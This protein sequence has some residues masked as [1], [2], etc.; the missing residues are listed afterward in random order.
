[1]HLKNDFRKDSSM[2]KIGLLCIFLKEFTS[3]ILRGNKIVQ[4]SEVLRCAD[5]S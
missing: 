2:F 1:M 3:A 4:V 5:N